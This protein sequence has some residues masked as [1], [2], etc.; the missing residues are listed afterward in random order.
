MSQLHNGGNLSDV[1]SVLSILST[2]RDADKK[3]YIKNIYYTQD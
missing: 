2:T 3:I 1:G